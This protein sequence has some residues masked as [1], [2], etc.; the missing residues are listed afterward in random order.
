M[1]LGG[2]EKSMDLQMPVSIHLDHLHNVYVAAGT[3]ACALLIVIVTVSN[4]KVS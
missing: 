1:D 2:S 4:Q 3:L